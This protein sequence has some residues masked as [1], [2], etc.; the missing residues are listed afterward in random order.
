MLDRCA[1]FI[2]LLDI[3]HELPVFRSLLTYDVYMASASAISTSGM[4]AMHPIM[5]Y[6]PDLLTVMFAGITL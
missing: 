4:W 5:V 6:I 2:D 1:H 3:L